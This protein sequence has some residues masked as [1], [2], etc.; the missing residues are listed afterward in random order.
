MLVLVM[1]LDVRRSFTVA[2]RRDWKTPETHRR[3]EGERSEQGRRAM[4]AELEVWTKQGTRRG[5]SYG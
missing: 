1:P 5:A 4:P 2:L 3:V